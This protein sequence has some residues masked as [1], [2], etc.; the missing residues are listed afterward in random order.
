MRSTSMRRR[1]QGGEFSAVVAGTSLATTAT[2]TKEML[3]SS[4]RTV[5]AKMDSR[6]PLL[7]HSLSPWRAHFQF[8]F[9]ACMVWAG[10]FTFTDGPDG[11]GTAIPAA[12]LYSS[13]SQTHTHAEECTNPRGP[14]LRLGCPPSTFVENNAM[15][16]STSQWL[17]DGGI[18][19]RSSPHGSRH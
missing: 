8:P 16:R 3:S 9:S 2:C 12:A 10:I 15:L 14:Y 1:A 13:Y 5:V 4:C 6:R 7:F 17:S 11:K 18:V 19:A